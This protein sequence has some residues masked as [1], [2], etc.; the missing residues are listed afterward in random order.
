MLIENNIDLFLSNL[1]MQKKENKTECISPIEIQELKAILFHF[2]NKDKASAKYNHNAL[3]CAV[4][5]LSN[6]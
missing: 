6:D 1:S 5:L 4:L 2:I 3:P